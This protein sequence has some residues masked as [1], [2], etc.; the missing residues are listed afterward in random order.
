[1]NGNVAFMWLPSEITDKKVIQLGNLLKSFLGEW[2][3]FR[4]LAAGTKHF[5][6]EHLI[7]SQLSMAIT[8]EASSDLEPS[9]GKLR[10]LK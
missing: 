2:K 5:A 1:M 4:C 9:G 7:Q 3:S 10:R 8:S 6:S